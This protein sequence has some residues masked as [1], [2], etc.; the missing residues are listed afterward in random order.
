MKKTILTTILLL[1]ALFGAPNAAADTP[2]PVFVTTSP[3]Y[4]E[5]LETFTVGVNYVPYFR[6]NSFTSDCIFNPPIAFTQRQ[7]DFYVQRGDL[8]FVIPEELCRLQEHYTFTTNPTTFVLSITPLPPQHDEAL[9][10]FQ[11]RHGKA[12]IRSEI[13]MLDAL[14]QMEAVNNFRRNPNINYLS[15]DHLYR[16]R[17]AVYRLQLPVFELHA[18]EYLGYVLQQAIIR[19]IPPLD[20]RRIH[21]DTEA[22]LDTLDATIEK[23]RQ[24]L[25]PLVKDDFGFSSSGNVQEVNDGLA[26]ST[27][28]PTI[29]RLSV[30]ERVESIRRWVEY[31]PHIHLDIDAQLLI[32]RTLAYAFP[33]VAAAR[34]TFTPSGAELRRAIAARNTMP[35]EETQ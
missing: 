18:R 16:Y 25:V 10:A 33:H 23:A 9:S 14:S 20:S 7:I 15:N 12:M 11:K 1:G 26:L 5:Y 29:D 8:L 31:S 19:H 28:N 17:Q 13:N 32:D 6:S 3:P 27:L 21:G 34:G 22:S 24:W 4:S 30:K 2:Q 35:P